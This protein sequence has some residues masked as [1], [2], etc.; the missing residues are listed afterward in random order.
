MRERLLAPATAADEVGPVRPRRLR[1]TAGLRR[2]VRET[3]LSVDQLLYP[4]FVAP[5]EAVE[6]EI[7]SLPGQMQ[8]SVDRIGVAAREVADAGI[9][10]VLLF[11]Q[12]AVKSPEGDEASSPDGAV[13][14]AIGESKRQARSSWCLRTCA[15]ARIRITAIAAC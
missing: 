12:A 7:G 13:Q 6:T 9:Q 8:R 3:R 15:C 4:M 14:R 2:L 1:R 10:G 5:G 11:G